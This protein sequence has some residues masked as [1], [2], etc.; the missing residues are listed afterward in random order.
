MNQIYKT[1]DPEGN[2]ITFDTLKEIAAFLDLSRADS[3]KIFYPGVHLT[4]NGDYVTT[5]AN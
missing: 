5:Y 3:R 4:E 2:A 1:Y